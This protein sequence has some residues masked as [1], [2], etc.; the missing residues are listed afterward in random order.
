MFPKCQPASPSTLGMKCDI[1]DI[2]GDICSDIAPVTPDPANTAAELVLKAL[3]SLTAGERRQ[4]LSALVQSALSPAPAAHPVWAPTS[5]LSAEGFF[6]PP[7]RV[8]A[9]GPPAVLPVR[10]PQEQLE[11]LRTWCG[12]HGFSMAVVIR[13]LVERFLE[14]QRSR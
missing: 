2:G 1:L 13:G 4:V 10:L 6:S 12:D 7:A 8:S 11:Q 9:S 5:P 3:D 14:S